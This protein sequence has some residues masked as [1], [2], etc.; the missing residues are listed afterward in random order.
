ML[1]RPSATPRVKGLYPAFDVTPP[2]FVTD[3]VTDRGVFAAGELDKYY[4]GEQ[5]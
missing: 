4:E 3:V 2:R 5:R 1:G